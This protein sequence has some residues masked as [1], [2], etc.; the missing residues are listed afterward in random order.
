MPTWT[1]ESIPWSAFDSTAVNADLTQVIKTAALVERNGA[2]YGR[3][4]ANVFADD[5]TFRSAVEAWAAEEEQHGLA[6][7]RWAELA[8]PSFN[9]DQ[10]F[11]LFKEM[12]RIPV[13]ATQ[14]VRGSRTGELCARCIVET[15]T[16][17]FYSALRDTVRDPV[18]RDVCKKIAAD[19]FRHYKLFSDHMARYQDREPLT[20]WARLKVVITRFQETS[21]DELASAYHAANG[22]GAAYDRASASHAYS[23]RA[24]AFYRRR[25]VRRAGHMMA[26]VAGLSP[27][28]WSTR[29]LSNALW[30]VIAIRGR[31]YRPLLTSS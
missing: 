17:S 13:D 6:L 26:Q 20:L 31:K 28:G 24:T 9:F 11:Q 3:Y 19:E 16:S 1:L 23:A 21:N 27:K 14:S 15:G 10:A 22:T 7:G 29:L 8:D 4:L 25:H 12:Y 18:L 5:S 2:D 30:W